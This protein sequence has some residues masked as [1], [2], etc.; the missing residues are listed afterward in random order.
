MIGVLGEHFKGGLPIPYQMKMVSSEL[1][2]WYEIYE[3]QMAQKA[4][5]N[6]YANKGKDVPKGIAFLN[7]VKSKIKEWNTVNVEE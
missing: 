4:V 7:K 5:I 6:E 2:M 1:R 3:K